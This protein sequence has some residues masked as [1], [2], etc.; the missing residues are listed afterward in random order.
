MTV[1]SKLDAEMS[2]HAAFGS[3]KSHHFGP[4]FLHSSLRV[5]KATAKPNTFQRRK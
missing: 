2:K 4:S 5:V 1:K 3:A